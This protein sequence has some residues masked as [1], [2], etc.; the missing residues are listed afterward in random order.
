MYSTPPPAPGS[1]VPAGHRL[2]SC[3]D[4]DGPFFDPGPR[5]RHR[6]LGAPSSPSGKKEPVPWDNY[7]KKDDKS[8]VRFFLSSNSSDLIE[9]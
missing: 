6:P 3:E 9:T 7:R 2:P 8:S 4:I 5:T 1:L